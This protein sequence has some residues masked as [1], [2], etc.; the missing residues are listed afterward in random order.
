[1]ASSE[2]VMLTFGVNPNGKYIYESADSVVIE[3]KPVSQYSPFEQI[4]VSES[5][6]KMVEGKLNIKSDVVS[7]NGKRKQKYSKVDV[8]AYGNAVLR[9]TKMSIQDR[10]VSILT[11]DEV[12]A[13]C[14]GGVSE[15]VFATENFADNEDYLKKLD[16][17]VEAIALTF[18]LVKYQIASDIGTDLIDIIQL[19]LKSNKKCIT[20]LSELKETYYHFDDLVRVLEDN[21]PLPY[22]VSPSKKKRFGK[23]KENISDEDDEVWLLRRSESLKSKVKPEML[24]RVLRYLKF[25]D[26]KSML[27]NLLDHEELEYA[28]GIKKVAANWS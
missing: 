27:H 4:G 7:K 2:V 12:E 16:L 15:V 9:N 28:V 17:D 6:V 5:F 23:G 19:A 25:N 11:A 22:K 13:G 26:F 18:E 8:G 1:M 20:R 10:E 3:N 24:D 21:T 14:K